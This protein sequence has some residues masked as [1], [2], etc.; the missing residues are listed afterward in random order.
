M[1]E[2]ICPIGLRHAP[3]VVRELVGLPLGRFEMSVHESHGARLPQ[4][5]QVEG[6]LGEYILEQKVCLCPS[7]LLDLA[8]EAAERRRGRRVD[9]KVKPLVVEV[10][11][12]GGPVPAADGERRH[13]LLEEAALGDV[14]DGDLQEPDA[15]GIGELSRQAGASLPGHHCTDVVAA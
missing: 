4:H 13:P 11:P 2:Q 6:V 10:A 14:A 8:D 3:D 7:V 9:D 12:E 1:L 15:A 5:A